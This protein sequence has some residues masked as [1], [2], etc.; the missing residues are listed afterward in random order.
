MSSVRYKQVKHKVFMKFKMILSE[1]ESFK[2]KVLPKLKGLNVKIK[3]F[4]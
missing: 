3:W 2:I 4:F 1:E